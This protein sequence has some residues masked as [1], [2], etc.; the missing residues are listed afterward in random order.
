[1]N[2]YFPLTIASDHFKYFFFIST[3]ITACASSNR[4]L[5]GLSRSTCANASHIYIPKD[6]NFFLVFFLL[7]F[8]FFPG[9]LADI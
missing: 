5:L 6:K 2:H 9:Q 4:L 7:R 1:M 3:N 8:D